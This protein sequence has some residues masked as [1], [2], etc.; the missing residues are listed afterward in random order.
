MQEQ[1]K[2]YADRRHHR[3]LGGAKLRAKWLVIGW[4]RGQEGL[5]GFAPPQIFNILGPDSPMGEPVK[6]DC[7]SHEALDCHD[8]VIPRCMPEIVCSE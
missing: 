5:R 7:C 8:L 4:H 1:E 3:S 6:N 2:W